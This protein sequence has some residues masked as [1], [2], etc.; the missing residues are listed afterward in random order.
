M[1]ELEKTTTSGA[2]V[3][4][5][6]SVRRAGRTCATCESPFADGQDHYSVLSHAA[7]PDEWV[8]TD[9]CLACWETAVERF[10]THP[11][12]SGDIHSLWR[13][14]YTD[15]DTARRTPVNEY[16]PLLEICYDA[17]ECD[18][19]EDQGLAYLAAMVLRRQRVF[20][21]IR[22][23]S[24]GDTPH[25]A[26]LFYDKVRQAEVRIPDP[27][28]TMDELR[29]TR[30]VLQDRLAAVGADATPPADREMVHERE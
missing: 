3:S 27:P 24:G 21:L 4:S 8:R 13:T 6:V 2:A 17:L 20:R 26:L 12:A 25:D 14:R 10:P 23:E 22:A 9:F 29:T 1:S 7:E 5:R 28:L 19:R 16:T 15:R 11:P 18:S 30:R